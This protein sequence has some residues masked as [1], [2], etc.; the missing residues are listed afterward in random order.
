M[1]C[2][3]ARIFQQSVTG[4]GSDIN[5]EYTRFLQSRGELGWVGWGFWVTGGQDRD[6]LLRSYSD[7]H[8]IIYLIACNNQ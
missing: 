3:R 6:G 1:V 7:H 8:D 5:Y 2:R 4:Y